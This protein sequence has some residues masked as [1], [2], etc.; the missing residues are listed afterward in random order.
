MSNQI[1][2]LNYPLFIE[3]LEN[4][5]EVMV[6]KNVNSD[7][8]PKTYWTALHRLPDHVNKLVGRDSR[9]PH[10]FGDSW[11]LRESDVALA[12]TQTGMISGIFRRI[13]SQLVAEW[14][15]EE[16]SGALTTLP[17]LRFVLRS[18]EE[19]VTFVDCLAAIAES[20]RNGKSTNLKAE[21]S[22]LIQYA[23]EHMRLVPVADT[24]SETAN[25]R[26]NEE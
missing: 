21:E 6:C 23:I 9:T 15:F 10:L 1:E 20:A 7:A 5:L 2:V 11:S 26:E 16:A 17:S 4:W 8:E 18:D 14:L 3:P 13:D 19:L 12:Y 22:S 25:G 24:Q